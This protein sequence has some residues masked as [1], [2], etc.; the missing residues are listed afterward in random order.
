MQ[1]PKR[2]GKAPVPAKKKPVFIIIFFGIFLFLFS[3]IL[4]WLGYVDCCSLDFRRRWWIH[5]LRSGRSSLGSEGLCLPKRICTGSWNG[6]KLLGSKGRE[7][8]SSN[9]WRFPQPSISS[10]EP[11][12]RTLVWLSYSWVFFLWSYVWYLLFFRSS[13]MCSVMH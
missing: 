3:L 1:A 13:S 8:S 12:I 4:V 9:A 7:G 5:C 10:L 2:G 6:P 11:L